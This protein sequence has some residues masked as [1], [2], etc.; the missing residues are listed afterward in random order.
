MAS[1][2]RIEKMSWGYPA[3]AKSP[4][5]QSSNRHILLNPLTGGPLFGDDFVYTVYTT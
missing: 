3:M 1:K 5:F 4:Y 2:I